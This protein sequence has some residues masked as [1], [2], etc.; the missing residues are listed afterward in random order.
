[1]GLVGD[2][3]FISKR[4]MLCCIHLAEVRKVKEGAERPLM[5]PCMVMPM[6]PRPMDAAMHAI[7]A[8]P[9]VTGS[10]GHFGACACASWR[11]I[12]SS[13][14]TQNGKGAQSSPL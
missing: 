7:L 4:T 11:V 10:C 5:P 9:E 3:H 1:M 13:R 8:C 2:V 14:L 12:W 6:L